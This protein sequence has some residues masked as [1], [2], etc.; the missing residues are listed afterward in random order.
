M[1]RTEGR[2]EEMV[3]ALQMVSMLIKRLAQRQAKLEARLVEQDGRAHRENRWL[4]GIP[5][6]K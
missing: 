1:D 4:Y 2:I 6:D 5:E 3:M